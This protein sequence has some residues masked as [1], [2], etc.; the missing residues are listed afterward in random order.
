MAE[1]SVKKAK[2]VSNP[3]LPGRKAFMLSLDALLLVA[4]VLLLSP[5]MTGLPLHEW[6]GIAFCL[7]VLIHLLIARPWISQATKRLLR[8]ADRRT[9]INFLLNATLF[10]LLAL[11][12][13]SGLVISQVATPFFGISTLN[14]RSLTFQR[15]WAAGFFFPQKF[16]SESPPGL[17]SRHR[18]RRQEY[19]A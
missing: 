16:G 1:D 11:E 6:M 8:G 15:D 19:R 3:L 18:H 4:F 14:D 5:R 12:I 2:E 7:P 17:Q 13:I 10:V 9:R